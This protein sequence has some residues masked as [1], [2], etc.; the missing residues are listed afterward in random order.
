MTNFITRSENCAKTAQEIVESLA[1]TAPSE[2]FAILV[3]ALCM[4]LYPDPDGPAL[5][6]TA[7][8]QLKRHAI[9]MTGKQ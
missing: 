8:D 2:R 7:I 6:A 3:T 4:V 5:L 1:D 9:P